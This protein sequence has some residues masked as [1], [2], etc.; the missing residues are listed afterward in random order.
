[1]SSLQNAVNDWRAG[2]D[3]TGANINHDPA[4]IGSILDVNG[5]Y[6]TGGDIYD[7]S[8]SPDY[9]IY[10]FNWYAGQG[11]NPDN[12][13]AGGSKFVVNSEGGFSWNTTFDSSTGSLQFVTSGSLNSLY[14]GYSAPGD[15]GPAPAE[16][17]LTTFDMTQPLLTVHG[18]DIAV[19]YAASLFGAADGNSAIDVSATASDGTTLSSI[20]ANSSL[21]DSVTLNSTVLYSLAFDTTNVQAFEW[22]LDKYLE[23]LGSDIT[24]SF[25]DIAAALE[26][27]G[28]EI[29]YYEGFFVHMSANDD[30]SMAVEDDLLL[31][32]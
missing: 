10:D 27:T 15:N 17:T 28:V 24:D 2:Y 31:A 6:Y 18:F 20:L 11:V 22:V 25:D 4:Y 14:L 12:T 8:A 21:Y 19:N 26:G 7:P 30:V 3:N 5:N 13:S 29:S 16:D 32:A 23:S 9:K 1:M